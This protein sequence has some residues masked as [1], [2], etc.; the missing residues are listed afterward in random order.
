MWRCEITTA[1]AAELQPKSLVHRVR[2]LGSRS[3]AFGIGENEMAQNDRDYERNNDMRSRPAWRDNDERN[4]FSGNRGWSADDRFREDDADEYIYRGDDF[5]AGY[6]E[7]RGG[8]YARRWSQGGRQQDRRNA[9]GK[10]YKD[11][12]YTGDDDMGR[13]GAGYG[14]VEERRGRGDPQG[15]Q[16]FGQNQSGQHYGG[17][18]PGSDGRYGGPGGYVGAGGYGDYGLQ[19][20]SSRGIAARHYGGGFAIPR[21]SEGH[22]GKGPKGYQRSDDRIREDVNDRLT[23]DDTLDA[24]DIEVK[25]KD[26]EVTLSGFVQDRAD[27]RLAEDCAEAVSGVKHVQNNIRVRPDQQQQSQQAGSNQQAGGARATRANQQD[28]DK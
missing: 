24:A 27:R 26:C 25:V 8:P 1:F 19:K 14:D 15:R 3:V 21:Q 17:F 7:E 28:E 12:F 5:G 16:V 22:R 9:S 2:R 20:Q 10:Q 23:D 4:R 18:N 13:Y 6:G 11:G